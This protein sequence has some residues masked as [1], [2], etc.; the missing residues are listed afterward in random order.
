MGVLAGQCELPVDQGRGRHP[1][2]ACSDLG[3]ALRL[4]P[5]H[6]LEQWPEVQQLEPKIELPGRALKHAAMAHPLQLPAAAL[7]VLCHGLALGTEAAA[8]AAAA[9]LQ[10]RQGVE[11]VQGLLAKQHPEIEVPSDPSPAPRTLAA[12]GAASVSLDDVLPTPFPST[13]DPLNG[14]NCLESPSER[15]PQGCP[16]DRHT[17]TVTSSF[18]QLL[19]DA[20]THGRYSHDCSGITAGGLDVASG[21]YATC[22]LSSSCVS[23]LG[24]DSMAASHKPPSATETAV[25]SAD[26]ANASSKYSDAAGDAA[27][28]EWAHSHSHAH[29]RAAA[30]CAVQGRTAT[31]TPTPALQGEWRNSA[32]VGNRC[33]PLPSDLTARPEA[34]RQ[35]PM[36]Q[37]VS[38][39]PSAATLAT[40]GTAATTRSQPRWPVSAEAAKAQLRTSTSA[41]TVQKPKWVQSSKRG[42]A[43]LL[44]RV[45]GPVVDAAKAEADKQ[46]LKQEKAC[47]NGE[48]HH[49]HYL[50]HLDLNA[51]NSPIQRLMQ[52]TPFVQAILSQNS[53]TTRTSSTYDSTLGGSML[54][55]PLT[56]LQCTSTQVSKTAEAIP[57]L[58]PRS[59]AHHEECS[60]G[61]SACNIRPVFLPPP[62]PPPLHSATPARMLRLWHQHQ[63]LLVKGGVR[64][65]WWE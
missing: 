29:V 53:Y 63:P 25:V 3:L 47:G 32:A 24:L 36:Q 41:Q 23:A 15:R 17:F 55:S 60:A 21:M 5:V 19:A 1:L 31:A 22:S 37:P 54:N 40:L 13:I 14:H 43:W 4:V 20:S 58:S 44:S 57:L 38:V 7:V 6:T 12:E 45:L 46:Q 27:P 8:A 51:K 18:Q 11:C 61:S 35:T 48:H 52:A 10:G 49:Y 30:E 59:T 9:L 34:S 62:P 56:S 33:V 2:W 16:S 39:T 50:Q 65:A 64:V 26:S 42:C 28:A